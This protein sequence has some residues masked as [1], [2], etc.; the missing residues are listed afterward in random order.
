MTPGPSKVAPQV[1]MRKHAIRA[2]CVAVGAVAAWFLLVRPLEQKVSFQQRAL[3]TSQREIEQF[4]SAS[5]AEGELEP[6]IRDMSDRLGT[7]YHWAQVS[8]DSGK[9]YEAIRKLAAASKVRIERI[10][11]SASR[12]V[13]KGQP[14]AHE[15]TVETTGYTVEVTGTYEAIATFAEACATQVGASRVNGLRIAANAPTKEGEAPILSGSIETSHLRLIPPGSAPDGEP[16][17]KKAAPKSAPRRA[18]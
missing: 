8:G 4:E 9:L 18:R 12:Q 2:A 17:N 5:L 1:D 6:A 3:A 10:E 13:T 14:A 7:M 15:P 11:P 16:A